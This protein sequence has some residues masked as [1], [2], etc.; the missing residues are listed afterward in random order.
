MKDWPTAAEPAQPVKKDP[1]SSPAL[2]IIRN[3]P[4][5]FRRP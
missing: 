3:G 4:E 5:D 1:P 2:S